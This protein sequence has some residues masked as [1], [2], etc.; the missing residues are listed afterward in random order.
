MKRAMMIIEYLE[1]LLAEVSE[2]NLLLCREL[3]AALSCAE[4]DDESASACRMERRT[5]VKQRATDVIK[6]RSASSRHRGGSRRIYDLGRTGRRRVALVRNIASGGR[7]I[8][9]ATGQKRRALVCDT[10]EGGAAFRFEEHLTCGIAYE[11]PALLPCSCVFGTRESLHA[12]PSLSR[13]CG[14]PRPPLPEKIQNIEH[15]I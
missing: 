4:D 6:A 8:D 12:A 15:F 10:A 14:R 7:S 2:E 13:L 11:R 3:L 1:K 9:A 5:H